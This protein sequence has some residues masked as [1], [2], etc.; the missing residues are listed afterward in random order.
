LWLDRHGIALF[1]RAIIRPQQPRR[2][3]PP[4]PP[5]FGHALELLRGRSLLFP[6]CEPRRL[7]EREVAGRKGVGVA[8]AE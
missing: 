6:E 8:D 3:A 1:D 7:L 5:A 2:H 4:R